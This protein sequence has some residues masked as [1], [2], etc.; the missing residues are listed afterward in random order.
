M[1]KPLLHIDTLQV[2]FRTEAGVV[3]AVRGISLTIQPGETVA[4][5]GESGSG[6]SVAALSL[7]QLLPGNATVQ[8]KTIR[9]RGE[10]IRSLSAEALRRLR[11]QQ[12]AMVFQE[13]MTAMN[14][15]QPIF[16]QLAESFLPE[17]MT[18]AQLPTLR[19]RAIE[20]LTLTGIND[21]E[22]KLDSYPHQLSGGQRQRVMIAMALARRPALLIADE[23][24][25]ALDVTIQAQILELLARLQ[26][27]LGM[28]ML[29]ITH[30]LPMVQ[31]S[32]D[33][34]YVMRQGEICE[35][36]A[37]ERLFAQPQHPYTQ[38]L[39]GSLP[40]RHAPPPRVGAAPLL[41]IENLYCHFPIKRGL[42]QRTVGHVKAVDGV[43]FTL[44]RGETV[45]IVGESGSGKT[46]LG[47]AIL[48]L[49]H[50]RGTIRFDGLEL[51][52]A[53][54]EHVRALRRR[55]QVVFQDPF[56]SLSPRMT[57]GEI[58]AEGLW[59]HRLEQSETARQQR[60]A[61]MLAEVGLPEA[62]LDR[63]PHQ[64]SGGQRQ[65]IAIARAMILHPELLVLDEP[66]SALDLSVQ[67]QILALLRGLQE[68]HG[69][70]FIFISHDLRVIRAMSHHILVL[71][72][73]QIVEQG[74]TQALF[75][76]PQHPY[77]RQLL[78]AA[79]HL[80]TTA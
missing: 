70:S 53:D 36:G 62:Y 7:L 49:N 72:Q 80:S 59:I 54:R 34:V 10:D 1:E 46:T 76:N 19:R 79:M 44:A 55:I 24:T 57:V 51:Q 27:E 67:A 15:V 56:S 69:L 9:L 61:A 37:T 75:D 22:Q 38:Q 73:G 6:K 71:W 16:R 29:L 74:P 48:Q 32:A 50:S 40:S 11:G 26:R 2:D 21:P 63:Y 3:A 68:R 77:T 4:L 47:E 35:S 25:T 28:A 52:T 42:L 33:R 12:I 8:A 20:L 45:G 78:A 23:P 60:A 58:L 41:Q 39:L 66:T 64:F 30:D 65:R 5:V 14:P 18:A 31:K 13:P 43:S 17:G